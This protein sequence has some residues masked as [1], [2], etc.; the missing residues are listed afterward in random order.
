MPGDDM[1]EIEARAEQARASRPARIP[2]AQIDFEKL[3]E[4]LKSSN[5]GNQE[6][7]D[8]ADGATGNPFNPFETKKEDPFADPFAY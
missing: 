5:Q 2:F 7:G 8:N 1:A 4:Q 6:G 3:G